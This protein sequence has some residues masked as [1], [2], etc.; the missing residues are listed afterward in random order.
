MEWLFMDIGSTLVD[1]EQCD[2]YR[3]KET[4]KQE[5]APSRDEFVSRMNFYATQNK[6]AYKCTLKEFGLNKVKWNCDYEKLYE[7]TYEV[8]ELL[9]QR[10]KLGII[11][12]QVL[13]TEKRLYNLGIRCFFDLIV[14]SA[15]EKISKPDLKIYNIALN[16]ANCSPSNA[17]MIGDRLDND[18]TPAI[19]IVMKT[20]WV[21]QGW[22]GMGSL[23]ELP[24]KPDVIISNFTD[25]I[26]YI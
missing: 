4:L 5:K 15:E 6:D 23:D 19:K 26:N 20:I 22:G 11:A 25:I 3:I 16:R 21:K 17:Y 14:T 9:H 18:I 1:E 13:G 24:K 7:G 8:L 2:K 10:F 12:N